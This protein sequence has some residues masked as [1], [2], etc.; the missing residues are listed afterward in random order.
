MTLSRRNVLKLGIGAGAVSLLDSMTL[1]VAGAESAPPMTALLNSPKHQILAARPLPLCD[2]RLTGGPLKQAQEADIKYLLEL[3]PDRMLAYYRSN[4]GLAQRA[5]PYGGWDGGG[6]NLTGHIAGHYLSAISAMWAATGDKR[7]K[8]R[9]DY[10][11]SEFKLVQDK[12]GDGYLCA[13]EGGR[14][15]FN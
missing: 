5:K 10:I 4:A 6:R 2:V 8:D 14:K 1:G 11:V 7:F 3:E 9:T 13:L 12:Q 15:C